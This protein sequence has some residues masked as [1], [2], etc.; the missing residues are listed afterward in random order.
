MLSDKLLQDLIFKEKTF[1]LYS[2]SMIEERCKNLLETFRAQFPN[3]NNY[4]AVKANSNPHLLKILLNNGMNF[5]CSSLVELEIVKSIL[6]EEEMKTRVIYT[7][8]YTSREELEKCLEYQ[9]K[10]NLDDIS[11]IL[12][13]YEICQ[14]KSKTFPEFLYL[15]V[16]PG[17]GKTNSETKSNILGGSDA[18]FGI[19]FTDLNHA[20]IKAKHY[21]TKSFGLHCMTGSNIL[22]EDYFVQLVLKLAEITQQ[23]QEPFVEYNLGGGLGI[24]YKEEEEEINLL[25]LV[26]KIKITSEKLKLNDLHNFNL[27]MENGRYLMGPCGF[28]FSEVQVIKEAFGKKFIGIN[29]CMS[30]LMRPGMY[31]AYHKIINYSS[32]DRNEETYQIVGNLCENNDWFGRDRKLPGTLPEDVICILDVGAHGYS[33]GFQYNGKLRCSEYL[34]DQEKMIK[35]RRKET[36]EDY[37]STI[38]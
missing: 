4:Y 26:S 20:I 8:N 30:N 29:A 15:R 1:Y 21:G 32:I 13:L 16:N 25:S 19:P 38:V 12:V 11:L 18:K 36:L 2:K 31:N 35:I 14:E 23:T 5:D 28:L 9:V 33:M 22:E 34:M 7:S 37:L 17:I 27:V 6:T 3:F 24:P 10:I